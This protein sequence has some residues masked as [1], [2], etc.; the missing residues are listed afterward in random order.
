M[1]K[2]DRQNKT[3]KR[4]REILIPCQPP[5]LPLPMWLWE[6]VLHRAESGA[7]QAP[8]HHEL[9]SGGSEGTPGASGKSTSEFRIVPPPRRTRFLSRAGCEVSRPCGWQAPRQQQ[10]VARVPSRVTHTHSQRPQAAPNL[11]LRVSWCVSGSEVTTLW[12]FPG[13]H[14]LSVQISH[15]I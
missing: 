12:V 3:I 11:R 8:A 9:G 4:E 5:V 13:A 1:N 10:G 2:Q 14:Y 7:A 15:V 6:E